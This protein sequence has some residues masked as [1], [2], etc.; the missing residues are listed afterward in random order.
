MES[1]ESES[2]KSDGLAGIGPDTGLIPSQ[3]DS[4]RSKRASLGDCAV[5]WSRG[6][7]HLLDCQRTGARV[8]S[9]AT[10]SNQGRVHDLYPTHS[11]NDEHGRSQDRNRCFHHPGRDHRASHGNCRWLRRS[12]ACAWLGR[13]CGRACGW[14][15]RRRPRIARVFSLCSFAKPYRIRTTCCRRS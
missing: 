13:W 3:R 10:G 8:F 14:R 6:R 11:R 12:L 5:G 7:P 15:S 4:H 1:S 2:S 9:A